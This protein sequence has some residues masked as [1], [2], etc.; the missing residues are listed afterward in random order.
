VFASGGAADMSASDVEEQWEQIK[1]RERAGVKAPVFAVARGLPP[2][3]RSWRMQNKAAA[4]GFD[5]PT[6]DGAL[7]KFAEE[8]REFEEARRRGTREEM[9]DELGD[10][11]FVLVRIGQKLDL[12]ADEALSRANRKF[13]ARMTFVLRRC[14]ELGIDPT[15]AGLERLDELWQQA[16]RPMAPDR[17]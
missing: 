12:S 7:A 16:K 15:E 11:L 9:L 17:P 2:L 13:E 4:A 14:Q 5:W 10:L 3:L 1:S 8:W 6:I